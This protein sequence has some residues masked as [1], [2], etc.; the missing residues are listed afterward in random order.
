MKILMQCVLL[1]RV[2][3]RRV[4]DRIRDRVRVMGDQIRV[5][6]VDRVVVVNQT[7]VRVRVRVLMTGGCL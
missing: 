5:R 2:V 7:R 4:R 6:V 3:R 1:L